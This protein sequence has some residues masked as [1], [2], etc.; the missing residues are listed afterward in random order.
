MKG[1]RRTI[2]PTQPGFI[3]GFTKAHGQRARCD[4][5]AALGLRG[6]MEKMN[7]IRADNVITAALND[8]LQAPADD[9]T[10]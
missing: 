4:A 10:S 2:L 5:I 1:G 9:V 7:Q 8:I 3:S 6:G